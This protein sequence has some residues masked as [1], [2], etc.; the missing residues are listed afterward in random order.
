MVTVEGA[1]AETGK[2]FPASQ[3]FCD[4]QPGKKFASVGGSLA[5][6]VGHGSRTHYFAR[7]GKSQIKHG[8]EVDVESESAAVLADDLTVFAVELAIACGEYVG[9]R[10]G[11]SEYIAETIDRP[12]LE[13]NAAEQWSRDEILAVA[14]QLPRLFRSLDVARK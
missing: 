3:H 8:R 11:R 10:R 9:R 12:T 6:I 14:Q 2:M 4:L 1:F 7:R 13:I 5:R